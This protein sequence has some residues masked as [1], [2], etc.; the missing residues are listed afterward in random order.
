MNFDKLKSQWENESNGGSIVSLSKLT[1][2]EANTAIDL[3]RK[4]MKNDFLQ[5]AIVSVV[6]II[7]FSWILFE[8]DVKVFTLFIVVLYGLQFYVLLYYYYN[9]FWKFYKKG[10]QLDLTTKNSLMWFSYEMKLN[11]EIYRSLSFSSAIIGFGG[12]IMYKGL[13]N[14]IS[15]QTRLSNFSLPNDETWYLLLI[16]MGLFFGAIYVG[17]FLYLKKHITKYTKQIDK[18]DAVIAQLN[19]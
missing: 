14:E 9:R 3:I 13:E 16:G 19:D 12:A 18:I 4:Y 1:A 15:S 2:H 5:S 6:M 10:Y 17:I 11:V 7:F 8:Q